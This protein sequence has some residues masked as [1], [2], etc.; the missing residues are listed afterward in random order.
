LSGERL[1]SLTDELEALTKQQADAR[2]KRI[3]LRPSPKEIKDFDTRQER[4]SAISV[5][6]RNSKIA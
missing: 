6:L 3:F 2:E 4:I 1:K 5:E